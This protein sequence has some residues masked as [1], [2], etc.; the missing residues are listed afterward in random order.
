MKNK[1]ISVMVSSQEI[2]VLQNYTYVSK[3]LLQK[4]MGA[5]SVAQQKRS[6]IKKVKVNYSL[7]ELDR[8]IARIADRANERNVSEEVQYCLDTL[9][10]RFADKYNKQRGV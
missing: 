5:F 8:I 2:N 6:S 7:K 10:G 1:I 4:M 9:F 3:P